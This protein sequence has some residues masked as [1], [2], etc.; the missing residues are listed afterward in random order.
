MENIEIAAVY[1]GVNILILTWLALR[2]GGGR[3]KHKVNLGTDGNEDM[4]LRVRAHGNATEYAPA[5]MVGLVVASFVGVSGLALHILGAGFTLGRLMHAFGLPSGNRF[6][7]A[8]GTLLTW[9]GS[10]AVA[11]LVIFHALV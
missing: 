9:V 2:V 1:V 4:E 11:G 5:F 10:L 6:L 3:I 7:R 8:G